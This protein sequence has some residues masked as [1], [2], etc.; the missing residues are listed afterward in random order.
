MEANITDY[1]N[2]YYYN[3]YMKTMVTYEEYEKQEEESG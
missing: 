1:I 3:N 2:D